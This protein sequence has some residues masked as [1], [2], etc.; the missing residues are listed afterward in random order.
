MGRKR[1][2]AAKKK[3]EH[4]NRNAIIVGFLLAF[5]PFI[6]PL[7]F[8]YARND[9]CLALCKLCPESCQ[10]SE[11]DTVN[12]KE[13]TQMY[14]CFAA[15]ALCPSKIFLREQ[16]PMLYLFIYLPLGA[17]LYLAG[18]K[19]DRKK[20]RFCGKSLLVGVIYGY[21]FITCIPSLIFHW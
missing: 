5:I 19:L 21:A 1:E 15:E 4:E 14:V 10:P 8:F 18:W 12:S 16:L 6:I 11:T 2:V 17:L 3:D 13:V 7:L 20:L 9:P